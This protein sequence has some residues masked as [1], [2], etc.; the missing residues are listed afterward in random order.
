VENGAHPAHKIAAWLCDKAAASMSKNVK[1][2]ETPLKF[3]NKE[4]DNKAR[5]LNYQLYCLETEIQKKRDL[6]NQMSNSS[7]PKKVTGDL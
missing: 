5:N 4:L 7:A 6:L 2:R 1:V 3:E